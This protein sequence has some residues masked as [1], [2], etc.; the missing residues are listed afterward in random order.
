MTESW[1]TSIGVSCCKGS[2]TT[3]LTGSGKWLADNSATLAATNLKISQS[4]F[5]SHDGGTAACIGL[6]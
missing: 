6:M 3:S 1:A 5:D 2:M 4:D